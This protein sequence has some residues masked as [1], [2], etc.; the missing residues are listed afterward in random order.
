LTRSAYRR[1]LLGISVPLIA[2]AFAGC[3]SLPGATTL[4][5]SADAVQGELG[6]VVRLHA[7]PRE[8]LVG[9]LQVSEEMGQWL[10]RNVAPRGMDTERARALLQ[11][12]TTLHGGRWV[13]DTAFTGTAQET[14]QGGRFNCLSFSHLYVALAREI[15]LDAYY[16]VVDRA[17]YDRQGDLLV[18]TGHITAGLRS[19]PHRFTLELNVGAPMDFSR[20]RVVTDDTALALHYSNLGVQ[21]LTEGDLSGALE[22]LAT[23][24]TIDPAEA[25][26]W[27][28]LGVGLRRAGMLQAAEEAYLMATRLDPDYLPAYGNLAV[29]SSL[30]GDGEATRRLLKKLD[31]RSTRNPYVL[32]TLGDWRL[33]E[34]ELARAQRL[35]RRAYGLARDRA[36]TRA[37]MGE[38]AAAAGRWEE[39]ARWL[40]RAREADP[41]SPRVVRLERLLGV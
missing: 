40:E 13:Y 3:A 5:P 37:A 20:G 8:Q 7:L 35:Y 27:V 29:L 2:G 25:L 30:R 26:A 24:V 1:A 31:S 33:S 36:D 22:G 28:N 21:R 39:A 19:G 12:L 11:R 23:A 32:L 17:E 15:G 18:T 41:E 6:E 34:G 9:P 38:W 4:E 14:F 16:L 10:R